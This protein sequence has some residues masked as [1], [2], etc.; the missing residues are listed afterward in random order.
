MI[1]IILR[2]ALDTGIRPDNLAFFLYPVSAGSGFPAGQIFGKNSTGIRCN[3]KYL[4][5]SCSG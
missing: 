4:C 3:P 5:G 1:D 2:D